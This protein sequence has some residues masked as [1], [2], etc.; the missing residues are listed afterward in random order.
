MVL[1]SQLTLYIIMMSG[2]FDR[3]KEICR[4]ALINAPI[5]HRYKDS[6]SLFC[7]P[8]GLMSIK[9]YLEQKDDR[10][11]VLLL[12]G[13]I[14][15][16]NEIIR[17]M[18]TFHP[19]IVGVSIQLLSYKNA[20][21]ICREA[22]RH[23]V[24]VFLGGH[25]ATQMAEK[26][27]AK[28]HKYIDCIIC[29]DGEK[30]VFGLC[31]GKQ[32]FEIPGVVCWDSMHN[33]SF[34]IPMQS[35]DLDEYPNPYAA[36]GI[37]FQPYFLNFKKSGFAYNGGKYYRM[38]S[39]KGCSFRAKGNRCVF[40]GRSD[41]GYRFFSV[42]RYFQNLSEMN[43]E[44]ND[45][46]FDVGDDLSGNIQWLQD[47]VTYMQHK[48]VTVPNIGIFGRGDEISAESAALLR[49]LGVVDVTIGIET[50][51]SEVLIRTGKGINGAGI[52]YQAA[53]ILFEN[54]IGITPSYVLGLPGE[55]L[56]SLH[57]T[58]NHARILYELSESILGHPPGEIVA[59][60]LEPIPGSDAFMVL[61]R[62]LPYKYLEEDLL[63]LETMQRDYFC[64]SFSMNTSS[65]ERFRAELVKAGNIINHLAGFADPQGWLHS[66]LQK[67]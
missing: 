25:H 4:I 48:S 17:Q 3:E 61:E 57:N 28:R 13:M 31:S 41:E 56:R 29:G 38:Y 11:Q 49:Q 39:H 23:G 44:K 65:Y 33:K 9:A 26:I 12:D 43:V 47:A 10:F 32:P 51:D 52:F 34:M 62:E 55:T 54:G 15:T 59:N 8:L 46:V 16:T 58:I 50:G 6:T 27:L 30:P 21:N 37:D 63:E 2:R 36:K 24:F 53:K 22:K 1:I 42:R 60:L 45:Y 35:C 66:E 18:N 20:L 40:C 7:P 5:D 19:E 64:T 67:G 14:L